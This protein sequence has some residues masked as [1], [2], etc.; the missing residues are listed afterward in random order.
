[1]SI[2]ILRAELER[3]FELDELLQLTR[4]VLGFDPEQVGGTAAKGSFAK[5][6]TDHCAEM[7]AVEAL[8]D[9]MLASKG[10]VNPKIGQIR[11][12][13]LPF[14]EELRS[15]A[16]LGDFTI[17]RKLGEGR[18]GISYLARLGDADHRVKVLRREATRDLRGLHR[19][20]TV[21]RLVG[22]IRHAGL[23]A[24]LAAGPVEDRIAV[25]HAYVEGQPLAV[26]IARTGPMHINEARP[27]LKAMLEGL[28]AIHSR[29][30]SH[31]D[32]RLENVIVFR[33]PDG[34]QS[35]VL[36]DAGSD[37]LRAR[38]R[39]STNG[40][41]ELFSTVGSPKSV[42]P[43]QIRGMASSPQSD[44]YSFG[45]L[46]FEILTGKPVFGTN[47]AISAAIGHLTE[48]APTPS[49]VAPRGW[50]TKDIDDWVQSMLDKDPEKR[51][52]DAVVLLEALEIM[53]RASVQRREKRITDA[54]LDARIAA[55]VTDPTDDDAA[56][57]LEAAVEE[58]ADA[59]RV[60]EAFSTAADSVDIT[61]GKEQREAKKGLLFRAA[62]L[63]EHAAKNA[64]KA[65][66][67]YASLIELDPSDEI[68][69]TALEDVRKQLGKYE[70][71]VEM[72]LARSEKAESRGERA[73]AFAEIGRLYVTELDDKEQALVAYTQAFTEDPHDS[74]HADE[75]ERLA[76]NP[77]AWGEVLSTCAQATL[78]DDLPQESK[79][80]LFNRMGRWYADHA[81]RLDLALP[82]YQAVIG[83]DPA[84]DEALDGMT[85]IYRKAQ[86]WPELVLVL[87]RRAD[88]AATPERARDFRAEAAEIL[89][90]QMSD[91]GR[92]RDLYQQVLA[93][94]PGH[95]R[96]AEALAKI[97]ERSGD[98]AEYVKLLE[99]RADASR[100][101]D[102]GRVLCHL[103]EI[104]ETRLNDDTEALRRY[105]TVLSADGNNLDALRGADRVLAKLGR[106][107]DL[108]GNLEK[109]IQLAATPRQ[110]ITLWERV[111]GIQDEEFLD[112]EK[113]AGAWEA[114][115]QID[116]AHEGALTALVRHYRA[117]DRWE[118]VA[119]LYERHI[120]LVGEPDHQLEL[121]LALGRVLMEQI[122]ATDRATVAYEKALEINPEHAGALEALAR[123][124][125]TA[126]DA[127]AALSAID[128][129]AEKASS[130]EAK[131]EQ[132][133]RAAKLLEGRGDRD[134]AIE[135]YKSALDANPGDAGV[136][137]SLRGAY[138]A[139]GDVNS[140]I[141]LLERE[142]ERTE[143]DRA[144]GKL[145]GEL[146]LLLRDRLKDMAKAEE[147]AKRAVS[148]DPTNAFGLMVLGDL[149]FDASRYLEAA[150]HYGTLAARADSLEKKDAVRVLV[151]YV[152]ALSKTGSTEEALAP[153]DTL[154]RIAPEDME[155]LGRVAQVTFE[156]GSPARA[157]DLYKDYLERFGKQLKAKD[158][159]LSMARY[160]EALRRAE[161]WDE[162]NTALEEAIDLDPSSTV[163]LESLAGVC[164]GKGDWEGAIK[165]KT[166]HLDV[167][168]GDKRADLLIEIGDIASEHLNDR[169][170]AT[171]S[172]VAALEE[173]PEDRRLL[174]KLM[175]L[176]SE[177][178][179]WGKLV[180]VVLR[181]ADF[182]EEP[183]QRAKY[184]Q[185][186]AIVCARQMGDLDRALEF[187]DRVLELD[188]RA[189]K[190]LV[191]AIELRKDKGDHRGVEKLLQ[192]K[193]EQATGDKDKKVMLE[194]FVELAELYEKHLN[195]PD[196]AI[197]ALEAAQTLEPDNRARAEH[198]GELYAQDPAKHLEKAVAAQQT[199]MRQNPY[200]P[201]S[202]KL[203]RKLY[204]E[205]KRADAAWN[206]CQALYV[207][208]LAEPDEERFFK[209]MRAESAAP[210]A[211]ALNDED[212]L[213][214]LV[215]PGADPL[216]TSVFALIEPAILAARGQAFEQLGYDPRY[217]IDLTRHP[218]PMS[219]TLYYSAGVFGM[220]APP[221]FQN[222][223]DPG[224]LSF[225]HA[226]R[227][228]LVL[229]MAALSADVPPQAAAF[230]A[231]RHLSYYR[232]GLY[233]RQI[234]P[235][236][237]GLKS[238]LFAAIKMIA[239]QFPIAAELEGPVNE[240]LAALEHNLQGAARDQLARI[241]AKLLQSGAALDL[242]RWMAGVDMTADRA[243]FLLAHDLETAVE[244]I[245]ASDEASSVV[246]GQERLK[247]LVLF[248][249]SEQYFNLRQK[250]RIAV[251]S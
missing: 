112:H 49:S 165:I 114:V 242:K 198:L 50:V 234:V 18:L 55:L 237:T 150:K 67:M 158:K 129:L 245:K 91:T 1:M 33:K 77:E 219:Q 250:L 7:D 176:Y 224:G 39:V 135:R 249:V 105:D 44:V 34:T 132:Y 217:A 60:A 152:D 90:I 127:D 95:Q 163:P 149:A 10:E 211:E 227:P 156:H 208:N 72:L 58:G 23:P 53:G 51:P 108:V 126:G 232:P 154:L 113:A 199:L 145:A 2:E 191:E 29:R 107:Q 248:S 161:R 230:I 104:Y 239:P 38:A 31:G 180:D 130:P 220:E 170:R 40:Q 92:A 30:L 6:L 157:V 181:L 43:E 188:P 65:E 123:L 251:D 119:S 36:L 213:T 155:A 216:L 109:Q 63:Y 137:A 62:R 236:G 79:N 102:R 32:L 241:V 78:Q 11:V 96:A 47:T 103:A 80:M 136:S 226:Y 225:L 209:R 204:T 64:E 133:L 93:D 218:Y 87:T 122:G 246:G 187:Y 125:E 124:R 141:K 106:F 110:K 197:D 121:T 59:A 159:A 189:D 71:L 146:A 15:G 37:R 244:I 160:G 174:T 69:L 162:A 228:A 142:M 186:A 147:A 8:C 223:N 203:L 3:L 214:L 148:F 182:V 120:K 164:E 57:A 70:E 184:L 41:N 215:H 61:S 134:G 66:Q 84:N 233:V 166:R 190:A 212:W 100:G 179:D 111:A 200:R 138:L 175:Q 26:R 139:R 172:Y 117:L 195:W 131:A 151:H 185:T 86:Q 19:F 73:R 235:S 81:T 14:D 193:L 143:G 167:A 196:R 178:K 177:E 205:V 238:W 56:V 231:G 194:T 94:D 46:L 54:D 192:R 97:Y 45:A 222:T 183:K 24:E 52:K 16:K 4:N 28:A 115:L 83:T 206:L 201:E 247:E 171:K 85:Q 17:V 202:Y 118:D 98:F 243:G 27:L 88:A 173:K 9:A 99:R 82:C 20:L 25:S 210:A 42:A 89:E 207:L 140:A 168:V 12:N 229:G 144:K 116:S 35:L 76:Q 74:S 48:A 22:T 21:S 221:T 5:A 128:A 240:A 13:G 68:A 101:E 169:T 75:L 153:M